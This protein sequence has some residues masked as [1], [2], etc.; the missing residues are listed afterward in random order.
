MLRCSAQNFPGTKSLTSPGES[1]YEAATFVGQHQSVE[2]VGSVA[3]CCYQAFRF[4]FIKPDHRL[5][6]TT[7]HKKNQLSRGLVDSLISTNGTGWL[8]K[9]QLRGVINHKSV[10]GFLELSSAPFNSYATERYARAQ[11]TMVLATLSSWQHV[12]DPV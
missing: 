7:S 2:L 3:T 1:H 9:N 4:D 8:V 6:P 10:V 5:A 11:K 12:A